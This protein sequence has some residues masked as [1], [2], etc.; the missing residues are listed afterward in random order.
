MR[1]RLKFFSSNLRA[2]V[3]LTTIL[4][5]AVLV[6]GLTSTNPQGTQALISSSMIC[7]APSINSL[8]PAVIAIP[9][10]T[11]TQSQVS[12]FLVNLWVSN[13][14]GG[15][16]ILGKYGLS[17]C[18]NPGILPYQTTC[19]LWSSA[20]THD[21]S[22]LKAVLKSSGLFKTVRIA[23]SHFFV[24]MLVPPV[25]SESQTYKGWHAPVSVRSSSVS[26]SP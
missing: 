1:D 8:C 5:A 15:P 25:G 12:R 19:V 14:S 9:K 11:T 21:A 23:K 22:S 17:R 7:K 16:S 3:A 6:F 26:V 18:E 4:L 20:A 10:S 24:T 13:V 2:G